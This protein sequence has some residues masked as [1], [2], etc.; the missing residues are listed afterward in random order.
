MKDNHYIHVFNASIVVTFTVN[1]VQHQEMSIV[2]K[3][4]NQCLILYI[5]SDKNVSIACSSKTPPHCWFVGLVS[6]V[7]WLVSS[8][9]LNGLEHRK[10]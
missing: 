8:T 9:L 4:I 3:S 7:F 5:F 1:V 10:Q 2:L 6:V